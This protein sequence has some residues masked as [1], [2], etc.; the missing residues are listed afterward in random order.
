MSESGTL[1]STVSGELKEDRRMVGYACEA[2]VGYVFGN[3]V[4]HT[5]YQGG[6]RS[7]LVS[8]KTRGW[9]AQVLRC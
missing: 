8:C 1:P 3:A 5:L 2:S 7:L 6:C 4:A 9:G